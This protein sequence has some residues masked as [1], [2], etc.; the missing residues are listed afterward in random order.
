M[1]LSKAFDVV[2][3]NLLI[4]K[5]MVYGY[6]TPCI[7]LIQNYLSDRKQRVKINNSRSK[8]CDVTKGVPQGSILGPTLFN[9][10]MNIFY[11]ITECPLYITMQMTILYPIP[12]TQ[13]MN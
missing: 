11:K 8:W 12:A 7:T 9:V 13:L 10:F 4:E 6:S 5:L 2:P 3:H 1:D